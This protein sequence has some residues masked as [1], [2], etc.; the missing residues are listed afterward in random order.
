MYY[1][2]PKDSSKEEVTAT[3]GSRILGWNFTFLTIYL[4]HIGGSIN[5]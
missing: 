4:A 5:I 1:V 3:T 2:M